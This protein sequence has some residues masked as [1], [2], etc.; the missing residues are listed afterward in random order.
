MP[1]GVCL[2]GM[3]GTSLGDPEGPFGVV[4]RVPDPTAGSGLDLPVVKY[5]AADRCLSQLPLELVLAFVGPAG[6]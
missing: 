6:V 4:D 3:G 1:P 5:L 2:L